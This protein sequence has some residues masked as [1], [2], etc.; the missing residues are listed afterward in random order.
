MG[1]EAEELNQE[2]NIDLA[3]LANADDQEVIVK[4]VELQLSDTEQ[5]AFDQGWRPQAD[6]EGPEDNWKTAKEYVRDGEF[7][8]T[9]RDLNKK[10]DS[11]KAD[12]DQR[13]DN[14]NKLHEAR[15]NKEIKDLIAQQRDAVRTSDT[16]AYDEA[17]EQINELNKTVIEDKPVT[18]DR[19]VVNEWLAKNTWIN[20]K[21]SDKAD[22]ANDTWNG[23][24]T[25]NPN[26]SDVEALAHVESQLTKFY[27]ANND[28]PRRNQQ[29]SNETPAKRG[30]R[31]S[32]ALTMGDLTQDE[33]KEWSQFG[34][35]FKNEGDFLKAVKDARV[36]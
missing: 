4:E 1:I 10:V 28:N 33:Q 14:S 22:F 9:I 5:K 27:P 2:E 24:V 3:A 23:Y 12:F 32:K 7:L 31:G 26:S 8:A 17:Q 36:N 29:N 30:K 15:K 25:R 21:S 6:F 13:L 20:D 35:M 34:S 18:N 16:E 19:P 11:Q